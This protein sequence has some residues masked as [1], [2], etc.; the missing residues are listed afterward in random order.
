MKLECK[1]L[2]MITWDYEAELKD[3]DRTIKCIPLWMW[4]IRKRQK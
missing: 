1:N 2:V 3:K 4:L